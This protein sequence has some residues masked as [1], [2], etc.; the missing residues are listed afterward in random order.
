MDKLLYLLG[1]LGC[2]AGMVVCMAM[3]NRGSRRHEAAPARTDPD[4]V[5]GPPTEPRGEKDG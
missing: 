4:S 3:M 5:A 2:A 1:P